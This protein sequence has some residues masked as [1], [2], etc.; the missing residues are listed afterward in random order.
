ML[1]ASGD[2]AQGSLLRKIIWRLSVI[3][4][5]VFVIVLAVLTFQFYSTVDTLRD[6]SLVSQANDVANHLEVAGS[7]GPV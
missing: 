7:S 4:G 3:T 1:M 6:R 2:S 5:V